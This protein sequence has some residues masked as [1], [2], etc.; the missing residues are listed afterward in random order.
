MNIAAREAVLLIF[1]ELV[2]LLSGGNEHIV[3]GIRKLLDAAPKKLK[4]LLDRVNSMALPKRGVITADPDVVAP[5]AVPSPAVVPPAAAPPSAPSARRPP[6]RS[7][8][9][10][11]DDA[12]PPPPHPPRL[13]R[14]VAAAAT[15][16]PVGKR[17]A[18]R[19]ATSSPVVLAPVGVKSAGKKAKPTK[20]AAVEQVVVEATTRSS[21]TQPH[22]ARTSPPLPSPPPLPAPAPEPAPTPVPP[23]DHTAVLMEFMRSEREARERAQERAAKLEAERLERLAELEAKREEDARQHYAAQVLQNQHFMLALQSQHHEQ[24]ALMRGDTIS[25]R[26]VLGLFFGAGRSGGRIGHS[27]D[28]ATLTPGSP[29]PS[30]LALPQAPVVSQQT[31]PPVQQ[32]QPPP[33]QQQQPPPVQQQQPAPGKVGRRPSLGTAMRPRPAAPSL[34]PAAGYGSPNFPANPFLFSATN[35]PYMMYGGQQGGGSYGGQQGGGSFRGQGGGGGGGG[36]GGQG[37]DTDSA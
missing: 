1:I 22:P 16:R 19:Q 27:F 36:S 31:P 8:P 5:T 17:E 2:N 37:D 29:Q 28:T 9:P 30:V 32:Q 26:E 35:N 18:G 10:T 12:N 24:L 13:T 11:K 21:S 4:D 23:P 6:R 7:P 14:R 34:H 15:K 3:E 20:S 33:V 25:S